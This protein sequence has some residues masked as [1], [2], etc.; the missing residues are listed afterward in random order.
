MS[1]QET[2]GHAWNRSFIVTDGGEGALDVRLLVLDESDNTAV[3]RE[4]IAQGEM[5]VVKGTPVTA[6]TYIPIGYK[7]A[8]EDIAAGETILKYGAPIG[9]ASMDIRRGRVVHLHNLR[10]DYLSTYAHDGGHE[11]EVEK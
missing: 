2:S 6:E 5:Y 7:I 9:T 8:L 4:R 11:A 3:V 1:R 10:S